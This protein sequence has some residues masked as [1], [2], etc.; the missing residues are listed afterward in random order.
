M[1]RWW[2]PLVS[3]LIIG[4]AG[5]FYMGIR[6]Y[7]D[8]PPLA[9]FVDAGGKALFD[10][11]DIRAGQLVF[12][13]YALMD[14]GSMFG[15][16][17]AR[18]PDF[19]A[20]ALHTIAL[21]MQANATGGA[22]AGAGAGAAG[23]AD[24]DAV[25]A[26]VQRA[27]KDM[28]PLEGNRVLCPDGFAAG[29]AAVERHL[30][31]RFNGSGPQAFNPPHYIKDN[32]ELHSLAAFFT[33]SAWV[34]VAKR[35]GSDASWTHN[36]PYDPEAGNVPGASIM[37]W[38]VVGLLALVAALGGV[39]WVHGRTG[40]T[41]PW[42]ESNH[43]ETPVTESILAGTDPT[44][45]QAATHKFFAVA[46]VLFVL[47]VVAGVLTVH[48]FL[49]LTNIF[50]VDVASLVP[51][52]IS[53]SWHIQLAILWIS[54]CWIG[55]A[56]Y[57]LP[58]VSRAQPRH[59][60]TLVNIV[61]ALLVVV[62]LGSVVGNYMGP[63]GMLGGLWNLL[64]H[65]GWEMVELGR[66]WQWVLMAALVLW[67]CVVV[68]GAKPAMQ[69][70]PPWSMSWWLVYAVCAIPLLFTAGFVA[71]EDTNFVIADFW[72][73]CVIHMWA[74]AF[75]EVFTTVIVAWMMHK[76]GLV[77][78]SSAVRIVYLSVLLYLGS[79]ILGISHNFYWN[80]KPM[81]TLAIGSVFSTMQVVPLILLAL[82]A[83]RFRRLPQEALRAGA[84]GANGSA[85]GSSGNFAHGE[86]FLF[87][88]GVNFWNF[89]GAG[90]FGLIINLPIMN[91]YEHG[92]YLT[93]NHGHAAL[94]GVY[95]NLAIAAMLWCTRGLVHGE[96]W[97]PRLLR[98]IFWSINL[99]LLLM[100]VLDTLP[101]GLIQFHEVTAAGLWS[102]RSSA[103]VEGD[104]FQ[105][106][107]WL[108]A[109]GGWIFFFGGVLPLAW[110]MATRFHFG[111]RAT[112]ADE[113]LQPNRATA[114]VTESSTAR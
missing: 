103:F 47:Q 21:T 49:G 80:A 63:K 69:G 6:T 66:L 85:S 109:V 62:T 25:R 3:V 54:T 13:K 81:A 14:Y 82:E 113:V 44:R 37:L 16:G 96:R 59:Q 98:F 56:I 42:S 78:R 92:T 67:M 65:Q 26:R 51:V 105:T 1:Q 70:E 40:G 45:L 58:S 90:V 27:L 108:R 22:G 52:T 76:M 24:A 19:S 101:L 4:T 23:A 86:A 11:D 15:D 17:A 99:G 71:R 75:F 50:G 97:S 114:A 104:T 107:T 2:L 43:R 73:W 53:R 34:C 88:L 36:W 60:V 83:W 112:V 91:Y 61:F 5:V 79:G 95:G 29:F 48:D 57:L 31:E 77:P 32:A 41:F 10:G 35:P 74:E 39:L 100:L 94:M 12:R 20:E 28:L 68:R 106:L 102:A 64:G 9:A 55:A 110:F 72:R 84:S 111:K 89:L 93:V 7:K 87:L 30:Q 18:G 38:S 46:A 33:W 8:A